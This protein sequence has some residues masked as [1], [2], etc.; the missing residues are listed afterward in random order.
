M[1][2]QGVGWYEWYIIVDFQTSTVKQIVSSL[3]VGDDD[4]EGQW[5]SP[6]LFAS[7][8]TFASHVVAQKELHPPNATQHPNWTFTRTF[9]S[10]GCTKI[11]KSF[12]LSIYKLFSAD[13]FCNKE[14]SPFITFHCNPQCVLLFMCYFAEVIMGLIVHSVIKMYHRQLRT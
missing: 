5:L 14:C 10:L 8:N 3:V 6:L 9:P 1:Y 7:Q 13:L 2:I 4:D 11:Y 12:Y